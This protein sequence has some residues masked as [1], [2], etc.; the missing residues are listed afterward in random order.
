MLNGKK[1][2]KNFL[3]YF[4]CGTEMMEEDTL[5]GSY[6]MES[7]KYVYFHVGRNHQKWNSLKCAES[8]CVLSG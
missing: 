8:A 5:V 4:G 7:S 1:G 3:L 2:E 6:G